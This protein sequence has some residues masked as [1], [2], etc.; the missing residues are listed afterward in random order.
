MSFSTVFG[1]LLLVGAYQVG[2][3][4]ARHPGDLGVIARFGWAWAKQLWK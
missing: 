4:N 3:Y 1:L 2:A